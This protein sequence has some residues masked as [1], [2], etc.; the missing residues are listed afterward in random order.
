MD[1][2]V[3]ET[4]FI[5]LADKKN[6]SWYY[7]RITIADINNLVYRYDS[8]ETNDPEVLEHRFFAMSSEMDELAIRCESVKVALKLK[9]L[10]GA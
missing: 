3:G 7:L 9:A 10:H 2:K 5:Y 4:Y 8:I 6:G 1:K